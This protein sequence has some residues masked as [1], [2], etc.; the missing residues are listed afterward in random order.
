[1]IDVYNSCYV[2]VADFSSLSFVGR[3]FARGVSPFPFVEGNRLPPPA[4]WG[5]N[6]PVIEDLRTDAIPQRFLAW[7]TSRRDLSDLKLLLQ[8]ETQEITPKSYN[9]ISYRGIRC[10][11]L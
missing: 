7:C 6:I 4:P 9:L 8:F 2:R 10:I 3:W 11:I 1:M 5:S